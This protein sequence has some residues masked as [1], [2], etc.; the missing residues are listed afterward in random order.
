MEKYPEKI[1]VMCPKGHN[2]DTYPFQQSTYIPR[3]IH[4]FMLYM[5]SI[6]TGSKD[7]KYCK[8]ELKSNR[9]PSDQNS[10]LLSRLISQLS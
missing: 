10:C 7:L 1:R 4:P 2:L 9:T 5:N 8:K 3:D 6:K